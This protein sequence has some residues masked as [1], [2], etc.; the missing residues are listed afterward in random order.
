MWDHVG[1]LLDY[2]GRDVPAEVRILKLAEETGEAAQALIGLRGWNPR[3]GVSATQ[4]EL[5][6]ELADVM[7]TAAVAMAGITQDA[8]RAG[9]IFQQRLATVVTR[10]GLDI[11]ASSVRHWTASAIVLHPDSELVLLIDH[12]KSGLVL[13]AGGHVRPGETLAEA[14]VREAREETGIDAGIITGPLAAYDPVTVH[15]SP[16]LTIEATAADPVNGP[17]QH[18][19]AM[20]VMRAASAQIG[21]LDQREVTGARWVSPDQIRQLNVPP[22]LPAITEAAIAWAARQA[23]PLRLPARPGH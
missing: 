19:D 3:K 15:P 6:D 2:L 5:L 20:F 14:A 13:F 21:Q 8:H 23:D 7:L 10:A 22:E 11:P 18:I 9:E 1:S 12:V 4:D 16:F 17:H